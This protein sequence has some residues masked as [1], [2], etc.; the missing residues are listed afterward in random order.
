MQTHRVWLSA[1]ANV[2][3]FAIGQTLAQAPTPVANA[4]Y[5]SFSLGQPVV[6]Q[7][8]YN[9]CGACDGAGCGICGVAPTSIGTHCGCGSGTS[10]GGQCSAGSA[11]DCS[12]CCSGASQGGLGLGLRN[13]LGLGN[14]LG[15]GNGLG[16]GGGHIRNSLQAMNQ[17]RHGGFSTM[18]HGQ[19]NG[20]FG[21]GGCCTP[22]WYDFHVEWMN[23]KR[24]DAG[25]GIGITSRG[26]G[27]PVV[28]ST[29]DVDLED[30][31]GFRAT[32]AF[33]LGPST[34][35]EG[36]YFGTHNWDASNSVSGDGDL[37]SVFSN[38]GTEFFSGVQGF[39]QT[40]DAA[41]FHGIEYS[42][43]LNSFELN[44]RRRWVAAGCLL[45]GSYLVGARYVNL[46]EEFTHN[47]RVADGGFLNYNV[48]ADN[49]AFGAQIGTDIYI[50]IS[51]RFKIG[52]EAEAG[53]YGNDTSV[54]TIVNTR[55]VN[56]NVTTDA[57]IIEEGA[58]DTDVAFVGEGGV[59]GL[60]RVTPR[61]TIRGG[62]TLLYLDGM[63]LGSEN[64]N[65]A[66]PF[67]TAGR[68]ASV[69]NGGEAFYHGANLGFTW[70]W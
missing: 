16:L 28:L 52:F 59:V 46:T 4:N 37:F 2:L 34:S 21:G 35:L 31:N 58:D 65:P 20:P 40:V 41:D 39:P 15:M 6:Q 25:D 54:S 42:S 36:S 66:S 29:N 49:D 26:A 51:P 17:A 24:D 70:M 67:S 22:I 64:F 56:G 12:A 27:G 44:C 43:E 62:Y 5:A 69:D 8:S 57:T 32:Y 60:F 53:V 63:A 50:C 55:E 45:H 13:G 7:L 9:A 11:G 61:F 48:E 33:L 19:Q 38:F 3:A 18:Q 30:A 68:I 10:C 47:T 14:G 23:L 1:L